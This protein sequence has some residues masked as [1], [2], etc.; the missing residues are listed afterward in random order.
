MEG[1]AVEDDP[2]RV[3]LGERVL[4]GPQGVEAEA[5]TELRDLEDSLPCGDRLPALELVE[6]PLGQQQADLHAGRS[7]LMASLLHQDFTHKS[8]L[9]SVCGYVARPT[10]TELLIR[11]ATVIDGSGAPGVQAS[12]A[13]DGGRIT[14]I[15]P[16]GVARE[17]DRVVDAGGLVLAPGFIDM[18]SHA[19]FTLPSYPAAINSL[20]QGVTT[21]VIGNCGYSPAPLSADPALAEEQRAECHGLGPDLDW[22]WQSFGEYLDRLDAAQPAVNVIA[23]V[24]HGMLRLSVVGPAAPAGDPAELDRMRAAADRALADGAW[25]MSTGLVYPPGSY[26]GTDEVVAVGGGPAGRRRPVRQ[27]HPQRERRPGRCAARGGRDRPAARRP[28][29]GVASQGGR[30]E[31]PRSRGARRSAILDDARAEGL[32]VHQD[33]YPYA[34]GS[35]LLTQLLPPW[36][37]DGGTDALVARLGRRRFVPGSRPT[38]ATACRAGPTTSSRPAAGTASA[39]RPSSTRRSPG[40]RARR[41]PR[42]P[43]LRDLDPFTLALD[44]MAADRGATMM[45]VSLMSDADVDAI[46]A[47]PSTSIGSDQLGVT[48]PRGAASTRGR[49]ARSSASWAATSVSARCS[50]CRRRSGG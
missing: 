38:S 19:D 48:Q 2:L 18:H 39:S 8:P 20:A 47:D 43:P 46:L 11:G 32:R 42:A 40:S 21:E 35:T 14:A 23:L 10:M 24:G 30:P 29:R 17:A 6:V 45:I 36:V 1:Q 7:L 44:T 15:D 22:A 37:H 12:V 16:G 49:T 3:P 4:A 50:T 25:G 28:G 31:Q 34:A 9:H 26:A 41:S 5:L 33:A 27:P 13:I